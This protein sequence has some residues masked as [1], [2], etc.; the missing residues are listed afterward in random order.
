MIVLNALLIGS[1]CGGQPG[2]LLES[3]GVPRAALEAPSM[4]EE[5]LQ[6][7]WDVKIPDADLPRDS[8]VTLAVAREDDG[9]LRATLTA[10]FDPGEYQAAALFDGETGE[11]AC[12]FQET[13]YGTL[14]MY[15]VVTGD[16]MA[17]QMA[18]TNGDPPVGFTAERR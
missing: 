17:G 11:M 2:L 7:S 8:E 9:S 6:G 3:A 1:M 16:T 4:V 10:S 13:P 18:F 15:A 14:T 5:R 12:E